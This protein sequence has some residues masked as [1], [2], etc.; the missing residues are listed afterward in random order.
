MTGGNY[1][2]ANG[3]LL[4]ESRGCQGKRFVKMVGNAPVTFAVRGPIPS[5]DD[6]LYRASGGG[7]TRIEVYPSRY[8]KLPCLA[9]VKAWQDSSGL[10]AFQA[11]ALGCLSNLTD[12]LNASIPSKGAVYT[13]IMSDC[14]SY[15]AQG[16]PR[17]PM[18]VDP[19]LLHDCQKRYQLYHDDPVE[20][21]PKTGEE[22]CGGG[23]YHTVTVYGDYTFSSGYL[24]QCYAPPEF[25]NDCAQGQMTDFCHD[26]TT[27][28]LT[29][30]SASAAMTGTYA[31]LPGFILDAG[32]TNLGSVAGTLRARV[33]L[34][35]APT[36]LIQEFAGSINFG[37]MVFNDNGAGSECS[38]PESLIPCV[39]HCQDDPE[40]RSE[41][42]LPEDCSSGS[43][44]TADPPSDGG[45]IIS[46][47]NYT[48]LGDHTPGSGLIAS[49]DGVR[50]DSWTPLAE[51][52]YEAIQY[53]ANRAD[54]RLQA[55][56]FDASRP[57]SR[58]SCQKN[59]ILLLTDGMSTADRA[60]LVNSYVANG[61][62]DYQA[63]PSRGL[64]ALQTTGAND[65]VSAAPAYQGSYNLDDLA[66]IARNKNI[67]SIGQPVRNLSD[68]IS[69]Y[70]AY[71]G[72][73]CGSYDAQGNCSTGDEA[74]PEKLMQLVA[75][76]GGGRIANA[77]NPADLEAA[78]RDLLAQIAS[79]A[80]S[81][82]DVTILSN[83]LSNGAI[84]L[85]EQFYPSKSF[86][87]GLSSASWIGEMQS[88]WYYIDPFLGSSGEASTIRE[89]S[90][91]DRKLNLANDLVVRFSSSNS[92]TLAQLYQDAGG[93]GT[94]YTTVGGLIDTDQVKSLWRAGQMLWSRD[95]A[96][97]PR[98]IY[99]P[100][101]AGGSALGGT[102]L[103]TFSWNSPDNRTPLQPLLQTPDP[104]GTQ[105]LMQYL[106]GYDSPGDPTLRSRTLRIGNATGV[107]RLGDIISSTP[108]LQSA[109]SLGSYHLAVP[110]GYGDLSYGR[111]ITQSAYTGRGTVYLGANDGMLHAFRLGTLVQK[112]GS[113]ESWP[114]SQKAAL[115]GSDPG[116]EEWAFIPG[117]VLP[118]LRFLKEPSYSHLSFVDGSITL[119]DASLGDPAQ[120][121]RGSYWNC[122]KDF[123]GGSNWRTVLIGG[124]GL[125]GASKAAGDPSCSEGA[126]GTC[127]KAPLAAAGLSSYFALDVTGLNQDGS[128][129]PPRLL[130]EFAPPGLGFATSGAAIVK[131]NAPGDPQGAKQNGRWFAV[132]AS[133]P[134]GAID[135][136]SCQFQGKSDQTLKLFVVDL[137]AAPPLTPGGNY[138]TIDT[139]IP[140]A[141]GGGMNGAGIDTD[142]WNGSAP[143][144]YEDD[145]LYLGY[146]AKGPD[147]NWTAGGVLRLLTRENPDP[148]QWRWSKVI[149]GVG[150]V[151][152][153][154]AKLQDRKNHKLWLYFGTGRYFYNQDD[155]TAGRALYGVK[156]PCY[157]ARDALVD[158]LSCSAAPLA[159]SDLSNASAAGVPDNQNTKGWWVGLDAADGDYGS[160]RMTANP[161]TLTGGSVVF[162]TFKPS[163]TVCRPGLSYLWN[164]KYDS[165][166]SS[167]LSG[168]ALVALSS[169]TSQEIALANWSD[170]GGR[171]SAAMAGR[172]GG[173]KLVTNSGLRPLKK[174]IHIQER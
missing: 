98:T 136:G 95:L 104:A 20:I 65:P 16:P 161:A 91:S 112:P 151:T 31:N 121:P 143:G 11:A 73:P 69:S 118:Y 85:Q 46:Y 60:D 80:N 34:S 47:I 145:A 89:D 152:G 130:W 25:D 115:T 168:I 153:S 41:C 26:M 14:Y 45:K 114:A 36:G 99:T 5:E 43:S 87:G 164:V 127:V 171:R 92:T 125:G 109:L 71:T 107:W 58:F 111:F 93:K 38:R 70:V 83:G 75:A 126:A 56:D 88:L 1:D 124:M 78:L 29:D 4:A 8:N 117:N 158:D 22:V 50:A 105:Q 154:V 146:T 172:P 140:N 167:T 3:M 157:T 101:L 128:V 76:K 131:I 24:G 2:S 52:F 68:T 42:Y 19:L 18:S 55:S 10:A 108:A 57:P 149:D 122:P 12:P 37:A 66:W 148:A 74:V 35:P 82:T 137:N 63:D 147:G 133:G 123:A 33:A 156:E 116:F 84:F 119:A 86:D 32:V 129:P 160:E 141:F 166:G 28:T 138:W 54:L 120:C 139:G 15:L 169:G 135:P 142:R 103:M 97:A 110:Q 48:P 39:K 17:P 113:G 79:P 163:N 106:Q 67:T 72:A 162:T 155:L 96:A 170:K 100:L 9:A 27:P 62:S 53:F 7:Q 77:R 159:L 64:P 61:V 165:A 90:D 132:F 21:L 23:V 40:P 30:P 144:Y 13:E 102:G 94:S 44:C 6:Y 81:G 51:S 150:P 174:I 173:V 134:T 49:L 59:S